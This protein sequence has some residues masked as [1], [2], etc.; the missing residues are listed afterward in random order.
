MSDSKV[1]SPIVEQLSRCIDADFE[2]K[3]LDQLCEVLDT[4]TLS[5]DGIGVELVYAIA[6][7]AH[8]L[9]DGAIQR[10]KPTKALF[11]EVR[12]LLQQVEAAESN[13]AL[14]VEAQFAGLLERIDLE[15]SGGFDASEAGDLGLVDG[16]KTPILRVSLVQ[17]ILRRLRALNRSVQSHTQ[18]TFDARE[19]DRTLDRQAEL[20]DALA[21]E[22]DTLERMPLDSLAERLGLEFVGSN[23]TPRVENHVELHPSF[24]EPL[25]SLVKQLAT[26]A[27]DDD[28]AE[29]NIDQANGETRIQLLT[30]KDPSADE[31]RTSAVVNGLLAPDAGLNEA[32]L[33]QFLW[34]SGFEENQDNPDGSTLLTS[35]QSLHGTVSTKRHENAWHLGVSFPAN[36]KLEAVTV[37]RIGSDLYGLPS[38]WVVGVQPTTKRNEVSFEPLI[39]YEDSSYHIIALPNTTSY[40]SHHVFLAG[41]GDHMALSVDGVEAPGQLVL[42]DPAFSNAWGGSSTLLDGRLVV[43]LSMYDLVDSDQ[44]QRSSTTGTVHRLLVLNDVAMASQLADRRL[45]IEYASRE[46]RAFTAFQEQRPHAV[47]VGANDVANYSNLLQLA[48]DKEVK[49]LVEVEAGATPNPPIPGSSYQPVATLSDLRDALKVDE[50][51]EATSSSGKSS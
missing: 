5:G 29:L 33:Q 40:A 45:R 50:N 2:S 23:I 15:A 3:K 22:L 14:H 27:N 12:D 24:V 7:L 43:M 46:T 21:S 1:N 10:T 41:A 19:V 8:Q 49:V 20:I 31:L 34:L 18:S 35:I 48:C 44:E 38:E 17:D 39:R 26:L 42:A 28:K 11:R 6:N 37:F 30:Q 36:T 47:L 51:A 32:E 9:R 25:I 4:H 13:R 16:T